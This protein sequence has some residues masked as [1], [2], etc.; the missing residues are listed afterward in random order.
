MIMFSPFLSKHKVP[1]GPNQYLKDR[2]KFQV[3]FITQVNWKSIESPRLVNGIQ[4]FFCH[5]VIILSSTLDQSNR[6]IK[7]LQHD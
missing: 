5:L 4:L 1:E 7:D 3:M 2:F 6:F